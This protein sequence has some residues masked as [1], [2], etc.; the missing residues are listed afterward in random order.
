MAILLVFGKH[1]LEY[2]PVFLTTRGHKTRLRDIWEHSTG[3][4]LPVTLA[5]LLNDQEQQATFQPRT[6]QK[7]CADTS[8]YVFIDLPVL[9]NR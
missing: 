2:A 1:K 5:A 6:P 9:I 3:K 7:L 8:N 4:R